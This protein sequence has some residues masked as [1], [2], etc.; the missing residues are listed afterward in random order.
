MRP[1]SSLLKK[2]GEAGPRCGW[3]RFLFQLESDLILWITTLV[4]LGG[5][6][7]LMILHFR[8]EMDP[9]HGLEDV[10]KA[11]LMGARFDSMVAGYFTL[12]SLIL[13]LACYAKDWSKWAEMVRSVMAGTAFASHLIICGISFEYYGEYHNQFNQWIY[14]L[15]TDDRAAIAQTI[16]KQYPILTYGFGLVALVA[17]WIRIWPKISCV[18]S[19]FRYK[20]IPLWPCL[21]Q[22][23]FIL[24]CGFAF[25][26]S[27]RGWSL[28]RPL[29]Q[30]DLSA[31]RDAFLNKLVA[32]PYVALRYAILDH[33]YLSSPGGL[34]VFLGKGSI[35]EAVRRVFPQGDPWMNLETLS[36]RQAGGY[37]GT[38]PRHIFVVVGESL[39]AWP[40]L[41]EFHELG[42]A[43]DLIRLAAQ[44]ISCLSFL[45]SG[46][47]TSHALGT[48]VSGL[49]EAGVNVNY[50]PSSLKPFTTAAAPIFKKLGYRTRFIYAGFPS[51]QRAD[52]FCMAQGFDEVIGV[53]HLKNL[54]KHAIGTWGVLDE[55]L[56][57]HIL[58]HLP[59]DEDSFNVVLTTLNHPPYEH[60]VR[61]LGFRLWEMPPRFREIYDGSSPIAFYGHSW[62]TFKS[63]A[64]FVRRAQAA[65]RPG[66]FVITGDHSSRRFLNLKP[67]LYQRTAV[68][69]V[70]LGPEV[71]AT[72]ARPDEMAGSHADIIPTLVEL[73]ASKGFAYHS[74]GRNMLAHADM[75]AGFGCQTIVTPDVIFPAANPDRVEPVPG[76]T[77]P[78]PLPPVRELAVRYQD[79]HALAWWWIMRGSIIENQPNI[80]EVG[81]TI[82]LNFP[83]R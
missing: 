47:A 45:S 60:D 58:A 37:S 80:Q 41:P 51:W 21:V 54:P 11:L 57:H 29:K 83:S 52:E 56:Y 73:C 61:R 55:F 76:K 28:M 82:P 81:A 66:L 25:F 8:G 42:L 70:L 63:A 50:Q 71:L 46:S 30:R 10:L 6:R 64:D 36:L 7:S 3:A 68:P 69:F 39:D 67:T 53:P 1:L 2:P 78:H 16:W 9:A 43:D 14:G 32:N 72:V 26:L 20:H 75:Q 35:Q 48:L 17:V 13:S 74:L 15:I 19:S 4:M 23:I 77:L 49:P 12:P 24:I 18:F 31:T 27:I 44:G 33:Q 65:F 5:F 34:A 22:W 62:Y 38:R 79:L 59:K 40:M